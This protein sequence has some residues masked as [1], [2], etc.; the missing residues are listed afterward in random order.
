MTGHT[1]FNAR[2]DSRRDPI[3]R[4]VRSE[5]EWEGLW[6]TDD[7]GNRPRRT[8][9]LCMVAVGA[10]IAVFVAQ[11]GWRRVSTPVARVVPSAADIYV[12]PPPPR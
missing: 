3:P 2:Y 10:A 12:R 9:E 5:D 8:L 4:K 6:H 7:S 11:R 1:D